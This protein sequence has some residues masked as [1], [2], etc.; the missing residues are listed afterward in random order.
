MPTSLIT[1]STPRDWRSLQD[2]VA[3]ILGQCGLATTVEGTMPTPRGQVELDVYA[4][5]HVKG[6]RYSIVCECKHWK[7]AIPQTVIHAFRTVV[8]EIGANVGYIIAL[9]GF[10]S[11]AKSAATSTNIQLVTWEEFQ[12][13][14]RSSWLEHH[15]SKVVSERLDPLIGFTEPML[16]NWML[17]IPDTDVAIVKELR[18]RYFA[19]GMLAMLFTPYSAFALREIVVGDRFPDLPIRKYWRAAEEIKISLQ[20]EILDASGYCELLTEMLRIGDQGIA[21]F[22]AVKGRNTNQARERKKHHHRNGCI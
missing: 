4:E 15:F 11:G 6:R 1:S 8:A 9:N 13:L 3:A 19:L 14:F 18:D 22:R 21:E 16:Q 10:Q 5:E 12:T 20:P 17:Q 7:A 2:E